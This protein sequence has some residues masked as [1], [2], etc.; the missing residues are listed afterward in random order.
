MCHLASSALHSRKVGNKTALERGV[1]AFRFG[2]SRLLEL[3][4]SSAKCRL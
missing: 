1:V 2:L 3:V 4:P